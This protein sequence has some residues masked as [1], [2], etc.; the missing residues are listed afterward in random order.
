MR[1]MWKKNRRIASWSA[2]CS[3]RGRGAM[4][5]YMKAVKMKSGLLDLGAAFLFCLPRN[6]K[7]QTRAE[8][9]Q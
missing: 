9:E 7:P 2:S 5:P 6:Q 1:R 3:R 4:A 8:K